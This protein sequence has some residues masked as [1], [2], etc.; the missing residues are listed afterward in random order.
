ALAVAPHATRVQEGSL[1][2]TDASG[3]VAVASVRIWDQI[4]YEGWTPPVNLME[5]RTFTL[6]LS[7]A[8]PLS[9]RVRDGGR[10]VA[11]ARVRAEW[12]SERLLAAEATTDAD[13]WVRF[14]AVPEGEIVLVATT[15]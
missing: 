13:G 4:C 15:P 11:G 9:V 6:A 10:P 2:A 8:H 1:M 5:D 12:T 7:R 3:R 14:A